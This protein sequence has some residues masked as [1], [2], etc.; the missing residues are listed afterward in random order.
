[1]KFRLLVV[2]AAAAFFA[3]ITG[4]ANATAQPASHPAA[5]QVVSAAT[6]SAQ[7]D[8]VG[9]VSPDGGAGACLNPTGEHLLNCDLA[10]DGHHPVVYYFRSTSPNTLRHFSDAPTAGYC[11]DHNLA[12]IP[13]SGWVDIQSCNYEKSTELSCSSFMRVSANG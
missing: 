5:D 1:M 8:C 11:V 3:L 9:P 7:A 2:V 4:A 6:M 13:E 10:A 12:N